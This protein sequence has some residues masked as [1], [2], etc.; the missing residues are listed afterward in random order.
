MIGS[1]MPF[2][3]LQLRRNPVPCSARV[4]FLARCGQ[5]F[6][7][8]DRPSGRAFPFRKE[9]VACCGFRPRSQRRVHDGFAPS[10]LFKPHGLPTFPGKH[11][12]LGLVKFFDD[13]VVGKFKD[14]DTQNLNTLV[15][16]LFPLKTLP[17]TIGFSLASEFLSSFPRKRESRC[18]T[19]YRGFILKHRSIAFDFI[20]NHSDSQV[21]R[22]DSRLRGNDAAAAS[23]WV[24]PATGF[25]PARE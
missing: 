13:E 17:T 1:G 21:A 15:S 10:S 24:T 4:G 16:I 25:P 7:L 18:E 23:F 5:V 3:I 6:W 11:T 2:S 19:S 12:A 22:L 8:P 14:E 9:T 20:F